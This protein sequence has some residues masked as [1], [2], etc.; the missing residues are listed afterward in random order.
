MHIY[1]LLKGYHVSFG[2]G[3]RGTFK[4]FVISP[5]FWTVQKKDFLSE[6]DD[7]DDDKN[8]NTKNH[9]KENYDKDYH[10]RGN[11]KKMLFYLDCYWFYCLHTLKGWGVYRIGILHYFCCFFVVVFLVPSCKSDD[12]A[13]ALWQDISLIMP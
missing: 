10:N 2:L 3:R 1:I 13:S 5:L 8:G 9:D 4:P 6:D 11:Q 7:H 12:F